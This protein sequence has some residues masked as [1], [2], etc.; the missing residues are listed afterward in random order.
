MRS[1]CDA[2][3]CQKLCEQS[4]VSTCFFV[5]GSR[6]VLVLL[7]DRT[8][9]SVSAYYAGIFWWLRVLLSRATILVCFREILRQ[10]VSDRAQI[11]HSFI[12]SSTTNVRHLYISVGY[13][14]PF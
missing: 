11:Q 4:H 10:H 1:Q 14:N 8:N 6:F 3:R 7:R 12:I 13:E 5:F 9:S 2:G